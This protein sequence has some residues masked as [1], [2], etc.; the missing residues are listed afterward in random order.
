MPLRLLAAL[1]AALALAPGPARA[2]GAASPTSTPALSGDEAL[3]RELEAALQADRPQAPPAAVAAAPAPGAPSGGLARGLQSLNPDL[4]AIVDAAGGAATAASPWSAGDDPALP[5]HASGRAAGFTVQELEVALSAV[6]D[7]YLKGEV[8]LAIPNLG[9]L[10]VEEAVLTTTSLPGSLQLRAGTFRSAFGRQNGQHLHTQEF[11]VR[12]LLNAAFLGADGLRGPG[13]QLSWLVPLP[14]FLTLY[15]EAFSLSAPEGP[16]GP[17]PS[18]GGPLTGGFTGALHAKAFVPLGEETS[19]LLGTSFA[20][21]RTPGRAEQAGLPLVAADAPVQLY[22]AELTLKW[23]PANVAQ[24]YRAV[25]WQSELMLRHRHAVAA[26]AEDAPL[27]AE[28]DGGLYSQLTAQLA[29]RWFLGL[30]LDLLGVPTSSVVPRTLR[31]TLAT[32]FQLSEFA[33]LRLQ[34][35][36][37]RAWRQDAPGASAPD[38]RPSFA[39]KDRDSAGL[40]LQLEVSIGAHGAHAF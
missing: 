12:P 26:K 19:L 17:L 24:G 31:G 11:A 34:G 32:T 14:F 3:R 23:K 33:R 25:S 16:G 9:G 35:F 4:S 18:F 6:A 30:R 21:G 40:I 15:G 22:G 37:E 36:F 28:W 27:D 13:A 38:L 29:R 1:I 2:D 10:E 20:A 5:A 39:T 7:P 8:Y